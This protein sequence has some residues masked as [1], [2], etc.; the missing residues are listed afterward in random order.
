MSTKPDADA[1]RDAGWVIDASVTMAWFF[2]DEATAFTD[3][4]LDQ[5]DAQSV[6][7]PQI[8]VLECTNVLQS[9][10]RRGRVQP[11]RRL[12]IAAELSELAVRVDREPLNFVALDRLASTHRLSAY[13]AAYLE[14]AL[15]RSLTLVSLD[16]QLVATATAL[17][18]PVLSAVPAQ[19]VPP[20]Q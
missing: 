6:W 5:M 10:Q 13:D 11:A 18:H 20:G 17:G 3:G 14:L 19:S 15:R 16:Q 8:W 12:A 4:I 2:A 9:A 7:A 1:E